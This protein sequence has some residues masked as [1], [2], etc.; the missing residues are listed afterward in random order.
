MFP[1]TS[2]GEKTRTQLG[3]LERA[4]LNHWT[5]IEEGKRYIFRTVVFSIFQ[6]TMEKEKKNIN[7]GYMKVLVYR[8]ELETRDALHCRILDAGTGIK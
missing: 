5:S 4:N 1:S 7:S 6:N 2:E 3:H 8:Q